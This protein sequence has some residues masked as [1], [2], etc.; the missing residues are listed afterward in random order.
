MW[1]T[2][3]Q[4]VGICG[5]DERSVP[6]GQA[7]CLN[8]T[9]CTD[10]KLLRNGNGPQTGTCN[11]QTKT[12]NV[13]AWCPVEAER[14][15]SNL[16]PKIDAANFTVLVKNTVS[17]P[18]SVSNYARSNIYGGD[19]HW[20]KNCTYDKDL[21]PG[22]P[23]FTL[24][25]IVS[26]IS[27]TENFTELSI[28]GA[29]IAFNIEWNC[30]LD[31]TWLQPTCTPVYSVAREDRQ[32]GVS[33]GYHF[34]STRNRYET[35]G[36]QYRTL[37][38]AYGIR[39]IVR[40]NGLGGKASLIAVARWL[41]TSLAYF[42]SATGFLTL[43]IVYGYLNYYI[44]VQELI[45]SSKI[46]NCCGCKGKIGNSILY[47]L[48]SG[49]CC[50]CILL[51]IICDCGKDKSESNNPEDEKK[52]ENKD[53][54]KD[55]PTERILKLLAGAINVIWILVL[56]IFMVIPVLTMFMIVVLASI[57]SLVVLCCLRYYK[58][59]TTK[60]LTKVLNTVLSYEIH[61]TH[62]AAILKRKEGVQKYRDAKEKEKGCAPNHVVI[63]FDDAPDEN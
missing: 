43:L 29:V 1:L 5:E 46:Y 19:E 42:T 16:K 51:P 56:V 14:K 34:R 38:K 11:L 10:G 37:V 21:S 54:N 41:G 53:A 36:T 31:E 20:L 60:R 44:Q 13:L 55:Y 12:C 15:E 2:C 50:C 57:L 40:V 7:Y 3:N 9:N 35:N 32:N 48:I 28:T 17:F 18:N 26:M 52:D 23:I 58:V 4:S 61:D 8:N 30:D 24:G 39:V 45:K 47:G 25:Q 33:A 59:N 6:N 49:F 63:T 22:C 62:A 27:P